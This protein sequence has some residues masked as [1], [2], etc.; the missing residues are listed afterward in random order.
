MGQAPIVLT[1]DASDTHYLGAQMRMWRERRSGLSL[2]KL[3]TQINYHATYLGRAER[4]EQLPTSE[5]VL[6]Y[7]RAVEAGG[8]LVRIRKRIEDGFNVRNTAADEAKPGS[9]EAKPKPSLEGEPDVDRP[10]SGEEVSLPVL[11]EGKVIYVSVPRRAFL[12]MGSAAALTM[13]A[14]SSAFAAP[15]GA[16]PPLISD[17]HP[18][19]HLKD[20][21]RLLI[22]MDNVMGPQSAVH[23]ATEQVHI[24]EALLKAHTG[25]DQQEL[26]QLRTQYAELCGWLHQDAGNFRAAQYWTDRALE[27]SY[28]TGDPDLTVYVLA[29]KSQLATDMGDAILA[30]DNG[31]AARSLARPDTKLPAIASVYAA[32]GLALQ[33]DADGANRAYDQALGSLQQRDLDPSSHWGVWLDEAYIEVHRARSLSVVGKHHQAAAGFT[34]AI[35]NLPSGFSRDRG[36]Y[37]ARAAMAY[38]GAGEPEQA[39]SVGLEALSVGSH[40]QSAR[41]LTELDSLND[42]LSPWRTVAGVGDFREA[43]SYTRPHQQ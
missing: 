33:Q 38:A 14:A 28:A 19:Q 8:E 4:G 31:Q 23:K 2:A 20:M 34:K 5:V 21:R 35:S 1:P 43:L 37:L 42:V 25:R 3:S 39:A 15:D 11:H 9:H 12:G 10:W 30:V 40:T 13:G 22:D 16:P 27:W 6:A 32:H 17:A 24:I 36:V 41:I 29:R 26:K 18:I 7:D